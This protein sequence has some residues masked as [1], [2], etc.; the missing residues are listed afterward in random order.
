MKYVFSGEISHFSGMKEVV[1]ISRFFLFLLNFG[2]FLALMNR[3][4]K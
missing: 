4:W 1:I 3:S 2:Q